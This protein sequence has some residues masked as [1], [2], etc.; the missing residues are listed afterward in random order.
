[1]HNQQPFAMK[2]RFDKKISVVVFVYLKGGTQLP[3]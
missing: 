2:H 3:Y 1:M